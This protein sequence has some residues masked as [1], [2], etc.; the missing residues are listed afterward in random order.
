MSGIADID[1]ASVWSVVVDWCTWLDEDGRCWTRGGLNGG[2]G[3]VCTG[4]GTNRYSR[5]EGREEGRK[6]EGTLEG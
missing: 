5:S 6:L 1:L 4:R 3:G 2:G